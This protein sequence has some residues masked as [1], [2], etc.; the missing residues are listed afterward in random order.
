MW[1]RKSIKRRGKLKNNDESHLCVP[2]I[3]A[4][5]NELRANE[6]IPLT[7]TADLADR[8]IR[9]VRCTLQDT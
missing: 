2:E 8:E 7:R 1:S 5:Q 4:S 9:H 3:R 6:L